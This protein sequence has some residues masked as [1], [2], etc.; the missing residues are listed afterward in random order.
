VVAADEYAENVDNDAFTNA[1]AKENFRAAIAAAH[2]LNI[3]PD[4]DWARIEKGLVIETFP[5]G[6]TREHS[7]YTG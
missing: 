1:A 2:I 4:P 6:T 7:T 5:D 3:A